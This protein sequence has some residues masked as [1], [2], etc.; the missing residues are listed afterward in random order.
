MFAKV[1]PLPI[2]APTF[3]SASSVVRPCVPQPSC[4]AADSCTGA[5]VRFETVVDPEKKLPS[6]PMYGV[7]TI[8]ASWNA[9]AR[10]SPMIV[11]GAAF[12]PLLSRLT[13][14]KLPNRG[15]TTPPTRCFMFFTMSRMGT[16][17]SCRIHAT[18]I[19]HETTNGNTKGTYSV[20]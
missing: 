14:A 18:V 20:W 6:A 16:C 19:A 11:D 4:V 12:P 8:H 5:N 2:V 10:R 1:I 9:S 13:N 7:S 3:C 15:M 17:R